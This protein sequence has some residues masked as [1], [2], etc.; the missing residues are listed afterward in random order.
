M[1][2]ERVDVPSASGET[3][4]SCYSQKKKKKKT[5]IKRKTLTDDKVINHFIQ[6]FQLFCAIYKK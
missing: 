5:G 2:E 6:I 4:K 1:I 3:L